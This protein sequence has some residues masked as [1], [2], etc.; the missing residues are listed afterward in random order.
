MQV[1]QNVKINYSFWKIISVKLATYQKHWSTS[2][3]WL[4]WARIERIGTRVGSQ[5]TWVSGVLNC[6]TAV[7]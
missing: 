2:G 1:L 5:K 7:C 6:F 3:P 4:R